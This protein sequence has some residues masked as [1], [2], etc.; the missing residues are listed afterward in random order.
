MLVSHSIQKNAKKNPE[1]I[2]APHNCSSK[3][4]IQNE[5]KKCKKW[6]CILQH[7]NIKNNPTPH[8]IKYA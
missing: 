5:M 3:H 2:K 1:L 4:G 7:T 6:I 8:N